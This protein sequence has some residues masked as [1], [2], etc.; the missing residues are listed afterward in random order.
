MPHQNSLGEEFESLL[1]NGRPNPSALA[2]MLEK[3]ADEDFGLFLAKLSKV[4]L[5]YLAQTIMELPRPLFEDAVER[6][7]HKKVA[8][9]LAE[10]ESNEA[11]DFIQR[12]KRAKPKI[13]E[14]IYSMLQADQRQQIARLSRY[15]DDEVGAYMQ[16]E[17]LRATTKER[18]E[19]IKK[20]IERFR[21]QKPLIP[22]IKVF[23]TDEEGHLVATPHFSDLLLFSDEQTLQEI[24]DALH[25]HKPLSIHDHA[26]IA[27]AVR[28]FEELDLAALA[29]VDREGKLVGRLLFDDIYDLIREQEETMALNLSG[30]HH[31]IEEDFFTAQWARLRWIF[32]NLGA[33]MVASSVVYH[34][35]DAIEQIVALAVLMPIVAAL[36]G[37][38]GNQAVTVT[39][40]RLA[41]G[42][43]DLGRAK[44][45][46]AKEVAIGVLN[47]LIVGIVV[48]ALAYFW[49]AKPLL[50]LVAWAA[51]LVNLS[52]AGLVGAL[53]PI[54][55]KKIGVDPAIASPLLLTT[56][57]D[58]MG[59]F[60][61]LG[62]AKALLL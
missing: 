58:A 12:L 28:L 61:F 24:I 10:L 45:I 22:L 50:G 16:V 33:I 5:P 47:G 36:G 31:E 48:G 42:E 62:L 15:R 8:E 56:T 52:L 39:V 7:P 55:F 17:M 14:H 1:K 18:L 19:D 60:V 32:I 51:I 43:I 26:P 53:L 25:P 38:V 54:L 34:F 46:L 27:D 23:V 30:V 3:I 2:A 41:L 35:Q 11:T 9:A 59:F 37:N 29:I 6:L 13:Y 57:T 40:R 20:K 4:P 49:F 21:K 44:S